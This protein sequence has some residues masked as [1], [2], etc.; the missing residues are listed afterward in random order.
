V[1]NVEE[2]RAVL[3]TLDEWEP[4]LLAESR[5]PGPRAN[6]ELVQAVA[7]EAD[8]PLLVH[9]AASTKE[10][11]VMCGAVGLGRVVAGGERR[12]LGRLRELA[13]D[14]R[15]RVREA[16]AMALQR[17]GDDDFD[18]MA[19]EAERW[20]D[21]AALEQRAAVVAL[22]EPRLLT[23]PAAARRAL[24]VVERVTE[25]LPESRDRVLRQA[26]GYCWSV[27]VAALPDEGLRRFERLERAADQDLEWIVRE[28]LKRN[29][30]ARLLERSPIERVA[31]RTPRRI[32]PPGD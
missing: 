27:T 7:E 12:H 25:S 13:A 3:R 14:P 1:S 19:T 32:T 6:L 23:S 20:A 28:N 8:E 29:R 21:G 16:V 26:L 9:L 11:L 15:W 2:Y 18:A 5:L 24:D 31:R 4:F 10:L 30:L 22:C 17:W